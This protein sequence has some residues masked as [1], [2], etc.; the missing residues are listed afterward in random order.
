LLEAQ[1]KQT[2]IKIILKGRSIFKK[3]KE[4]RTESEISRGQSRPIPF[5]PSVGKIEQTNKKF[6]SLRAN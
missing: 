5:P 1:T 6:D 4:K 3:K 2:L